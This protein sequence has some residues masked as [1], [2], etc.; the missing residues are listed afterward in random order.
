MPAGCEAYASQLSGTHT[1]HQYKAEQLVFTADAEAP[2]AGSTAVEASPAV[3]ASGSAFNAPVSNRWMD[4]PSGAHH[5]A[6]LSVIKADIEAD[7]EA[8]AGPVTPAAASAEA[9]TTSLGYSAVS[10]CQS[11][12]E[13]AA[14][15]ESISPRYSSQQSQ[16]TSIGWDSDSPHGPN[17]TAQ[18]QQ[19]PEPA[20]QPSGVQ[21]STSADTTFAKSA[22]GASDL[23]PAQQGQYTAAAQPGSQTP[24]STHAHQADPVTGNASGVAPSSLRQTSVSRSG[25][26][27]SAMADAAVGLAPNPAACM[28]GEEGGGRPWLKRA[29]SLVDQENVGVDMNGQMNSLDKVGVCMLISASGT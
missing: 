7:Q 12:G 21:A 8:A 20:D 9:G 13:A 24:A 18:Q 29:F 11:A 5:S 4:D 22:S 17:D 14:V 28:V 3:P 26:Q 27:A 10:N 23:I 25:Q 2:S 19:V 16:D 15:A 1:P 6:L